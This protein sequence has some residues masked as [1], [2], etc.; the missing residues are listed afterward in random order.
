MQ[1]EQKFLG[2]PWGLCKNFPFKLFIPFNKKK[3]KK[4]KYRTFFEI[5]GFSH[6][7]WMNVNVVRVAVI[8]F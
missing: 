3:I 8:T 6:E 2:I 4:I 5:L 7:P 1:G